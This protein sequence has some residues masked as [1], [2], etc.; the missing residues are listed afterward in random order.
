L[1]KK[2]LFEK[3]DFLNKKFEEV[4]RLDTLEAKTAWVMGQIRKQAL[5]NIALHEL[6]DYIKKSS[7]KIVSK[8]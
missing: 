1:S 8:K 2:E 5:G 7:K 3:V 6:S 4:K